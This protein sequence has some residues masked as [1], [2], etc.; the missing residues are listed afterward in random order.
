MCVCVCVY[1]KCVFV[2]Q[3]VR[4]TTT[5]AQPVYDTKNSTVSGRAPDWLVEDRWATVDWTVII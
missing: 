1:N 2:Q 5:V 3:G 4:L